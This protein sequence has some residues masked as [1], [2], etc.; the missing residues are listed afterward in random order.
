[1]KW[2]ISRDFRVYLEDIIEAVTKIESYMHEVPFATFQQDLMRIDAVLRNLGIIGEA[3]K[4]I[5]ASLKKKY[6]DVE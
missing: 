2:N 5:P 6:P 1:V 3:S 4:K